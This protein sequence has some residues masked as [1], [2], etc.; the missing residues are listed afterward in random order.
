MSVALKGEKR[1]KWHLIYYVLAAF[2]VIT[3]SGSLYL[4]HQIMGIYSGSVGVNQEWATRLGRLADL[5]DFAQKTNA[6][7]NDVFDT[8]QV[9]AERAKREMALVDFNVQ[10]RSIRA[11]LDRFVEKIQRDAL[12]AT[13]DR[14]GIAMDDMVVEADQIFLHFENDEDALAGRRMATMDR[15]YA[16]LTTNI[17]QVLHDVQRIQRKNFEQQLDNAES[18]RRFEFLIGAIIVLMVAGVTFYGHAIAKVMRRHEEE[19]RLAMQ[20][21]GTAAAEAAAANLAKSDFLA[22]MS[23]EIRTPMNAVL[24]MSG[25]LVDTQLDDEQRLHVETIHQSGEALLSIID[26]ILDISKI[27]A[28]RLELEVEHFSLSMALDSIVDLLASRAQAKGIELA[29]YIAP[30]V[31]I[32]LKGDAGRLRQILLNL[33]GNAIKFTEVGGVTVEITAD[34]AGAHEATLRFKVTDTGIGIPQEHKA[35]LFDKFTQADSSTS[36][37]FGGTGLGLAI[38]SQIVSMMGGEIG[39]ESEVDQGSTFWFTV[40]LERQTVDDKGTF[41]KVSK[42]LQSRQVLVVDPSVVSRQVCRKYLEALGSRVTAVTDGPAALDALTKTGDPFDLVIINHMMRRMDGEELRRRIRADHRQDGVKL[43][44]SS[45][46]GPANTN[47]GALELGFDAALPKPLRRSATLRCLGGLYGLDLGSDEEAAAAKSPDDT[48][49]GYSLRI[50]VAEDNKANQTLMVK[51]LAK[52]GHRVDVA[53]NGIETL[54]A[55]SSRPYDLVLMDMQMPEMDGL[56]ATR[57]IRALSGAAARVPII[58]LTA[59]AMEGDRERCIEAGMNDYISKPIDRAK[60][61]EQIAYWA[62]PGAK[63]D[64]VAAP[65]EAGDDAVTNPVF[66]D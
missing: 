3:V 36:R 65:A 4:N 20:E 66:R 54:S 14:I 39:V 64:P 53:A 41:A 44:L 24:G 57:R 63:S 13:L 47:A 31:P 32:N 45:S 25:L 55:L 33:V 56:E 48:L 10:L 15:K 11:D 5:G 21:A 7:G 29:A 59:N 6:P 50:L 16:V 35:I 60:L 27:E 52:L 18:L 34:D 38:A 22:S 49:Q 1:P 12:L 2:D 58:A 37:R 40:R 26:D 61:R 28:G 23:H 9:A 62:A 43:V 46:S 19:L 30:T 51:I 42:L 17:S 8:H